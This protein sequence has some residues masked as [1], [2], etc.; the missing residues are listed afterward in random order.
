MLVL[1]WHF[2]ESII[3]R[4]EKFLEEGGKLIFPLPYIEII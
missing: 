1:P 4:E 3:K 2:R